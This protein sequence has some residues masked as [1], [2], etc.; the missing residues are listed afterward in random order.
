M[1]LQQTV[2]AAAAAASLLLLLLFL[3]AS[4]WHFFGLLA[5]IV[6]RAIVVVVAAAVAV[7]MMMTSFCP[8]PPRPRNLICETICVLQSLSATLLLLPLLPLSIFWLGFLACW[9]HC[10]LHTKNKNYANL[11]PPCRTFSPPHCLTFWPDVISSICAFACQMK[12]G[13]SGVGQ[14]SRGGV[15]LYVMLG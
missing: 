3:T 13:Y 4:R 11:T 12:D 14:G 7:V 15:Q 10:Y 9:R 2:A 1:L 6:R 8:P 5:F